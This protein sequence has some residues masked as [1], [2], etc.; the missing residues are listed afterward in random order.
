MLI[1]TL[2]AA[3]LF[4]EDAAVEFVEAIAR[5]DEMGF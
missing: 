5:I 4:D 3:G 1:D 2:V